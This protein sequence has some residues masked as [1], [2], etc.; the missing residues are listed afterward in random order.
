M[1][2]FE[3]FKDIIRKKYHDLFEYSLDLI[4][5]HDLRGRFIDANDKTL[6]CLGF[7]RE[8]MPQ[9]SFK[10]LVDNEQIEK[11]SRVLKEIREA[12]A[13]NIGEI[14]R[15][16]TGYSTPAAIGTPMLL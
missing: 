6:S 15:P 2:K 3:E 16:K 8:D 11:A 7:N 13:A 9:I 4:Y 12:A 5:V 10:D 14:N 1:R